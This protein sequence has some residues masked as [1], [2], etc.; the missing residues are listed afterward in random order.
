MD[1]LSVIV[2]ME[3]GGLYEMCN[4]IKHTLEPADFDEILLL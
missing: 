1:G 3:E 2:D 4:S